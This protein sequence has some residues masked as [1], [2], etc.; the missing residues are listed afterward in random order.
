MIV[1]Y[2]RYLISQDRI[3]EF[4][5]AYRAG[6][7]QLK[8][9]DHCLGYELTRCLEESGRY[10]LR[11]EWDSADGHLEGFRRGPNFADFYRHV[12]PFMKDIEEMRHY[13]LTDIRF[14]AERDPE[15]YAG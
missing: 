15:P 13:E 4:Q 2:I 5:D 11:I 1:E 8:S 12:E 6:G 10:I 9:S 3:T 7:A 14:S